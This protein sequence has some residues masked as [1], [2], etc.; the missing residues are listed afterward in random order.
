MAIVAGVV[1]FIGWW[2]AL[3]T[4][5]LPAWAHDF[6]TGFVRWWARVAAYDA[7][8]TDQY[9]PFTMDDTDYPVRLLAK[10]TRLSR[11]AVFFRFILVIPAAVLAGVAG[12]G[13]GI[14]SIFA[15]LITLIAGRMPDGLHEA[16]TALVRYNARYGGYVFLISPEQPWHGLYGDTPAPVLT[17]EWA[18]AGTAPDP[19]AAFDVTA[20]DPTAADSTPGDATAADATAADSTPGDA[21][22][23]EGT[24]FPGSEPAPAFG[25]GVPAPVPAADPW[26]LA[27]SSSGRTLL[28]VA[29]IVGAI[30]Y[31]GDI[32]WEVSRAA[33]TTNRVTAFNTLNGNYNRLGTVLRSF[34]TKTD[35]CGQS[36]SCVTALDSQVAAAFR[37]FGTGL[38]NAGVPSSYS[39]D[40][41]TLAADNS[42]VQGD[43]SQLASAQS[44]SQYTSIVGG[45]SL[46]GDLNAW[47][48]AYNKLAG[49]LDQ[50]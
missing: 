43:F 42:K 22:A 9:P 35:A 8:L 36:V 46:T 31:A 3:F 7:F 13:L 1:G 32:A 10:P 15:W 25:S 41:S 34:Q 28:T 2:A 20:A 39:A 48:A 23:A 30:G 29:L 49:E 50:P 14:L 40:T 44:A 11:L 18:A 4:G 27:L 6:L 16:F 33:N 21:T 17:P 24:T 47:Q 26:R 45:L 5:Q 12:F 37:S 38:Q 19:T